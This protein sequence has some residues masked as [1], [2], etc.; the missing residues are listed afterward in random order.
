MVKVLNIRLR[1]NRRKIYISSNIK[2]GF[3]QWI[4]LIPRFWWFLYRIGFTIIFKWLR[5]NT[6][7]AR[8]N[9]VKAILVGSEPTTSDSYVASIQNSSRA[10]T[11]SFPQPATEL[12]TTEMSK[13]PL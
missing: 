5:I 3:K 4:G 1:L 13:K 2:I 8:N 10:P 9:L 11:T 6:K 7:G 12:I